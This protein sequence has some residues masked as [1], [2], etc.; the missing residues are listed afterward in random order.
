MST[1]KT[2][3][4]KHLSARVPWHDN[5]WNGTFC[6]NVLD[7]SFCRILPRIDGSKDSDNEPDAE[8]ITEDNFPPC[9]AEKGT[10]LSP[11]EYTRPLVHAWKDINPLYSEFLPSLYH[12]KP[13]SFNAVPFLWMLKAKSNIKKKELDKD[14]TLYPHKSLRAEMYELDYRPE[15]EEEIDKKLGFSDNTWVQHHHNQKVL[16]DSFFDCLKKDQSLIF[17]YCKHTPLSEPNERVIIG[18]AKV[19]NDIGAIQE[20]GFPENYNGH[21][22]YPWDRCIEHSLTPSNQEGFLLPYHELIEYSNTHE[23][24]LDEFKVLATDFEQ[25][26]FASELVEHDIA[27]DALLNMAEC[28]R[29]SQQILEKSYSKELAWI[30]NEISKVWDMR[31][32]F[33]GMGSILS[34]LKIENANTIAW[35]IEKY[36]RDTDGDLYQTNPWQIFEE[37]INE[38]QKHIKERGAEIFNAT[39]QTIWKNTPSKKKQL[40]QLLS[41]IQLN[42]E[43]AKEI[44]KNQKEWIGTTDEILENPY[45]LYE[46]TC[47]YFKGLLSFKQID[48]A[49]LPPEKIKSAFPIDSPSNFDSQ[50]DERRIRAVVNWILEEAADQGH[51]I[52]TFDDT[53]QRIEEKSL[54]TPLPINEDVLISATD[55]EFFN[56]IVLN[57]SDDKTSFFK[58]TRLAE[59]KRMIKRKVNK[60]RIV[61]RPH[62][63]KHDWLKIINDFPE[64]PSLNEKSKTYESELLAR[65]EKAEALRILTNY[66]F[67]V[68]I[69]PAGSGKTTLLK[70]FQSIPEIEE[71]GVLKLAPTG[72]ARVKL[73]HDAMTIAQFLYPDRYDSFYGIYWT[74]PEA[75]KV[76]NVKT[77]IIDEASMLT[78]EQLA[79]VFDALGP[80]DRIILVGDYRQLPP[81]GTGRPFVD[82][83]D[84]LKPT[85]FEHNQI[86]IGPAY[87]ELV[88]ILRQADGDDDERLDVQLSKCFGDEV[89]KEDIELFLSLA[90]GKLSNSHIRLEK[91]YESKDFKELFERVLSEELGIEGENSSK[92]FNRTLGAVDFGDFQYFN[93][94]HSEKEIENWQI[95]SPVN[96]FG[97]GVKEVNKFIQSTF[98]KDFIDLAH[99][100]GKKKIAKPKGADNIVYGDKVINLQNTRWEDWQWV[101]PSSKK[102]EALNY[103]ANGEIGVLTGKFR[104]KTDTGK[105]EPQIEIAF[106]TQPGYSYVFWPNQFGEDSLKSYKFELAYAITVHKSQGSGFKKVFFV[107]PSK[108]AILSRELLY[109]ALT[110]QE[111]KIIILHQGDFRDFIRLA[112][113][114]ASATARRFTDLFFMPDIKQIDKKF[115]DSRYIN[116][117]ERGE[118]MIS[119]NEVI[120]ANCLNKYKDQISYAYEDKLK[121]KESGRTIKP[122]FTVENLDTGRIFYWE[123][124]GMLT[125]QEYRE[126]WE[127]K[128]NGYLADGFVKHTD[129]DL[130]DDKVLILT[131]ENP[132]GGIDSQYI[133]QLVR[134]IILEEED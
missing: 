98:R 28:L 94:D 24:D 52:L 64:L 126:N 74:N 25:F 5:K 75:K 65:K 26:S 86:K 122:D 50:L 78:E 51:S 48:K 124:L 1:D 59:T 37:S 22:G 109:T 127:K 38:P 119:K 46:K 101:N 123:H 13:Y 60:E 96:G 19:R 121:L 128:L 111:D 132:N 118:R 83:V 14:P 93:K 43:Q 40:L 134:S 47:Y 117:S 91:W 56:E 30:D 72:K 100:R 110:R 12:H 85:T 88:Q 79:A 55:Q 31:G 77:V 82:I 49:L 108:G 105:G 8:T 133:D 70:I 69:G 39:I 34:A 7:N 58:L 15:L 81:I 87:A 107:L 61:A 112:S 20:Y 129:T 102:E 120:I 97:Y 29:K 23:I 63:I 21:I 80:V 57:V 115:Y 11:N 45:I 116:V 104:K 9:I 3:P 99:K 35:E 95:I 44:L 68:L 27:I 130:S 41:R 73:G 2:L 10:F 66:R 92:A 89:E 67:S 17:F 33:P 103:I 6:C 106:S 114:D 131:E 42:N 18:V 62:D 125:K 16:L 4:I 84:L 54:D 76:S 32:A 53:L 36:I 113:T 90:S 71:G